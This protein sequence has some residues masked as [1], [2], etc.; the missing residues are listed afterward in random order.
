LPDMN[1]TE[2]QIMDQFREKLAARGNR[3]IM[4]LGRSFKIADD[5][6]SGSLGM[7][8]FQKAIHDFRVGL[9]AT[10]AAKLF[11]VFD[12]DGSGSIDYEEF[13]RGVRGVMNEFR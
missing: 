1:R 2:A 7:E 13:L 6:R 10:Q 8:E 4:G 5:D 12:R 11:K 3:G 9:N